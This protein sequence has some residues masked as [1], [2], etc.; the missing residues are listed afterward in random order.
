M[1]LD[2]VKIFIRYQQVKKEYVF[3]TKFYYGRI[4][5][6]DKYRNVILSKCSAHV[7]KVNGKEEI[8]LRYRAVWL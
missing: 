2:F 7:Q 8:P 6:N 4:H 3:I 1:E 5:K